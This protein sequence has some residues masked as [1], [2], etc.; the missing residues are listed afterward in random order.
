MKAVFSS[1]LKLFALLLMGIILSSVAQAYLVK[2][3][4][5]SDMLS[6]HTA[7]YFFSLSLFQIFAFLL[8]AVVWLKYIEP[9]E[10]IPETKGKVLSYMYAILFF[11]ITYFLAN[12]LNEWI[13]QWSKV[14]LPDLYRSTLGDTEMI[15]DLIKNPPSI[16]Y[17]LIV[18]GIIPAIAEELFFRKAIFGFLKQKSG[19]F[20]HAALLSSLLFAGVHF[21]VLQ[22]LPIFLLGFAL[23]FAYNATGSI[24]VP[25]FLHAINNS[26]QVLILYYA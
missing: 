5:E 25:M 20:V 1:F 18:V 22:L 9:F 17:P 3:N 12:A 11:V 13:T 4:L 21:Q 26:I 19:S 6:G 14:Y 7:G 23:A 8:P 24:I 16:W 10:F 2:G 15:T